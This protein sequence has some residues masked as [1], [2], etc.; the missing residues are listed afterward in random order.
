MLSREQFL[1]YNWM[2]NTVLVGKPD[3][4]TLGSLFRLKMHFDEVLNAFTGEFSSIVRNDSMEHFSVENDLYVIKYRT[5]EGMKEY[6]IDGDTFVVISFRVLDAEGKA[7]LTALASRLEDEGNIAVPKLL[8][9]IFPQERRSITIAY[10]D[11]QI[12]EPVQCSFT[13]PKQAEVI[14]R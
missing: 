12:N 8:R 11:L 4:K 6:R 3:G 1:F 13:I 10:D 5:R 7:L 14:Y 2:E 9:V